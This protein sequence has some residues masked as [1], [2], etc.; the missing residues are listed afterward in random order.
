MIERSYY[1]PELDINGTAQEIFVQVRNGYITDEDALEKIFEIFEGEGEIYEKHMTNAVKEYQG[2]LGKDGSDNNLACVYAIAKKD[3]ASQLASGDSEI[4]LAGNTV[5]EHNLT[6]EMHFTVNHYKSADATVDA[7]CY[8]HSSDEDGEYQ[9][10]AIIQYPIPE[11]LQMP[12]EELVKRHNAALY[13]AE[14]EA[15]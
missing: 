6:Q 2:N 10:Q 4:K 12:V 8:L 13:Y 7:I 1:H 9:K 14:R 3:L 15:L 11:F 5:T